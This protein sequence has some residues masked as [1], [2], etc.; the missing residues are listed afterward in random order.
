MTMTIGNYT[1][2]IG[3]KDTEY[4]FSSSNYGALTATFGGVNIIQFRSSGD[5]IR[6]T[7]D[8]IKTRKLPIGIIAVIDGVELTFNHTLTGNN[9]A[10][11]EVTDAAAAAFISSNVGGNIT[12]EIKGYIVTAPAVAIFRT[13]SADRFMSE[14]S[15]KYYDTVQDVL[16]T[17]PI[18]PEETQAAYYDES[19]LDPYEKAAVEV[20]STI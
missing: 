11:F 9:F 20:N 7:V 17:P 6:I 19:M 5:V 10:D 2:D 1:L 12:G 13:G 14:V 18:S 8:A 15:D 4:G 16:A 3:Q